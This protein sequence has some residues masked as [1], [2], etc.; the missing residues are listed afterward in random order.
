[1]CGYVTWKDES[2][3]TG[4]EYLDTLVQDAKRMFEP[5]PMREAISYMD[6]ARSRIF[7]GIEV[8]G[9]ASIEHNE[10]GVQS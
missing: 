7:R 2:R 10:T 4:I 6:G 1:M 5:T 3:Y 9:S 8:E